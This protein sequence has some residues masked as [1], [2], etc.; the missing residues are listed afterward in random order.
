MIISQRRIELPDEHVD[1]FGCFLQF[2]YT[3]DYTSKPTEGQDAKDSDDSGEQLLKHARVYTLAEKLGIPALKV[4]A[5]TKIHRVSS[6]PRGE[7]EYARYVYTHTSID[8]VTLRKPIANFWATRSHVLRHG[9]E[10]ELKRLCLDVPEFSYDVL[11]LVLENKE[12]RSQDNKIE[13]ELGTRTSG[14]KRQRGGQ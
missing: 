12:K 1:A 13:P 14:R 5:H 3:R 10:G 7:I 8:D 9:V 2:Q 11:A 6:T 4:L